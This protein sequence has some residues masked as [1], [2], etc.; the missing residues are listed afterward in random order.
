M[1]K[2]QYKKLTL[3]FKRPAGTSRG[4]LKTK[5]S[6]LLKIYQSENPHIFGLGECSLIYG[7]SPDPVNRYEEKLNELVLNIN[8]YKEVDLSAFPS[9]RFGLETALTDLLNGGKKLLFPSSFTEGKSGIPING[10][11]WMGNYE[12]MKKQIIEKLESGYHCVKLKI[13]AINF[14][15]ELDLLKI[16]RKNFSAEQLELRVDA[17]GAFAPHEALDKLKRLSD[18]DVHSI[19]QPVK[20]GNW[21]TMAN[22]CSRSPVDIA[23][24]EEL[25]GLDD[26]Q[27]ASMLK[28]IKPQ[29]IILKPSLTGGLKRSEKIIKIAEAQ[30]TGWWVTSAL[31]SNIGLNAI[32][33]WT[34]TL[35]NAMPQGLGTGTLYT[36]NIP[37]PLYIHNANLCFNPAGTWG[38]QM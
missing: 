28:T 19:E 16:I 23:L 6:W 22:L 12:F 4:V 38:R 35:N 37:S 11:V 25:I 31:E 1:L 21:E 18:Y 15:K 17:N 34:A 14:D 24:D 8:R 27:I 32:A 3:V 5:D 10:L 9:I 33:Q 30:K 26:R 13:G 36:N 7:L 20:Q 29:Y 2:A